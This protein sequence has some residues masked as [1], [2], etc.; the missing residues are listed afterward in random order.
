MKLNCRLL[1]LTLGLLTLTS[2]RAEL[3]DAV[4]RDGVIVPRPFDFSGEDYH[5]AM[6][7][8]YSNSSSTRYVIH[9][10]GG[11]WGEPKSV[12]IGEWQEFLNYNN[13]IEGKRCKGNPSYSIRDTIIDEALDQLNANYWA[14]SPWAKWMEPN[15]SPGSGDGYFRC[16]GLVEYCYEQAGLNPCANNTMLYWQGP[17]YQYKQLDAAVQTDPYNVSMSYPSSLDPNNPTIQ[18]YSLVTLSASATDT[19]SGLSYDRPFTYYF[20][21][22]KD[23]SWSDWKFF[24]RNDDST[25]FNCS[26]ARTLHAFY[27]VAYDNDGNTSVSDTYYFKWVPTPTLSYITISGSTT[28]NKNSG[29]QYT[30]TAYYSDGSSVNVSSS[31]SWSENSSYATI[32][33][34]GYLTTGDVPSDQPCRITATYGGKSATHDLTIKNIP[35]TLSY[36]T[37]S[38]STTVNENSGAQY[39][40][41][42]Y[43]SDG[44]SVNVS[45]STSWSENSSYATINGGGYLTTGEVPSDQPCRITATYG[46]RSA[47]Y[48]ITIKKEPSRGTIHL[49]SATYNVAENGGKVVIYIRRTGGREGRASVDYATSDGSATAGSDYTSRNGTL[50][51]LP[52]EGDLYGGTWEVHIPI[53]DNAIVDGNKTFTVNL[54]GASGASLGSPSSATVTIIDNDV[55]TVTVTF[56]S[57]DGSILDTKTVNSGATFGSITGKPTP[58]RE[59]YT[60][61]GKWYKTNS[62]SSPWSSGDAVASNVDA[63]AAGWTKDP[64]ISL[65]DALD[66]PHLSWTTSENA[67]W[68]G[69][70]AETHDGVDAAQ[71]GN[72][73]RYLPSWMQTTV[74][75]PGIISFWWKA[76]LYSTD[77][78]GFSID[79]DLQEAIYGMDSDSRIWQR[80]SL[81][82]PA[83]NHTLKWECISFTGPVSAWVDQVV[84]TPILDDVGDVTFPL[85]YPGR[86]VEVFVYDFT[87]EEW[88]TILDVTQ[89]PVGATFTNMRPNRWYW[90]AV[91]VWDPNMN[92]WRLDHGSWFGRHH[93]EEE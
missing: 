74:T 58:T 23:G 65:A 54:S 28:V 59:G 26:F 49:G 45:S 77:S 52:G 60:W 25:T 24:E 3:A 75:G 88:T 40:C 6:I 43:Y 46:G 36:V 18:T 20:A 84:F 73:E 93:P 9:S 38:G 63:W 19:H 72:T 86:W 71:S 8:R 14:Q 27:V 53:I 83:G 92:D 32:N 67:K 56:K 35:P 50:V 55:P 61:D 41:T 76:N 17:E 70:T 12:R 5:A 69:Q 7:Y 62:T 87:E 34:S 22:C 82:V 44:S 80:V 42:A 37:I 85:S 79:N 81:N 33:G 66:A 57:Y 48:D 4:Y 64:T 15:S 78:L 11:S 89:S 47:T 91:M 30:C 90:L 29:A 31:A 68:F 10:A 51:W 1:Y 21:V 16:D 39:T 13:Y 2:A